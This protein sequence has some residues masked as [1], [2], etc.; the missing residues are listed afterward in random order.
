MRLNKKQV[1]RVLVSLLCLTLLGLAG[2]TFYSFRAV[3]Q[4]LLVDDL[5]SL[6]YEAYMQPVL[7]KLEEQLR[8]ENIVP[9]AQ[10]VRNQPEQRQFLIFL[11]SRE[12]LKQRPHFA[13]RSGSYTISRLDLMG[14]DKGNRVLIDIYDLLDPAQPEGRFWLR[15]GQKTIEWAGER[16][17][18]RSTMTQDLFATNIPT[19]EVKSFLE[20]ARQ[21]D[22]LPKA[23]YAIYFRPKLKTPQRVRWVC[24]PYYAIYQAHYFSNDGWKGS[25]LVYHEYPAEMM[26]ELLVWEDEQPRVVRFR[27]APVVNLYS[28]T[29]R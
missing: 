29:S 11:G 12:W 2:Y 3:Q 9:Q 13:I 15:F 26:R 19:A 8:K 18:L 7:H 25:V 1:Y 27:T 22:K 20:V 6:M 17:L 10:G 24:D 4:N 21:P 23:A 28:G 14:I 5:E 16:I